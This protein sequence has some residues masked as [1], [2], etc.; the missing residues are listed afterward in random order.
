MKTFLTQIGTTLKALEA[1]TQWA[2]RAELG[3]GLIKEA[4]R[5]D[6]RESGCPI[7][8]W[9]HCMERRA[10]IYNVTSKKLFQLRGSNP[11][12]VTFGTQAD[13]SNL[14]HFRELCFE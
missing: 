11:H 5:K 6:L 12:T 8:L 1:E 3:I 4:T 14:C 2:N 10:L 7:V 13:I 9:D